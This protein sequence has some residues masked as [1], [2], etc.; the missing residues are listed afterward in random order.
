MNAIDTNILVYAL[1]DDEPAKS[2]AAQ[3]L[4][5]SLQP[6]DT[7]LLWQVA[8]EFGAVV[9]RLARQRRIST[10]EQDAWHMARSRFRLV[11]PEAS[12]LELASGLRSRFGVSYWD[13]M[14]IA[15]CLNAGVTTL[16]SEDRQSAPKIEGIT[17]VDPF[18]T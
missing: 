1:S 13:S 12:C 6:T 17:I 9:A 18:R 8:V 14:I 15:A 5:R 10:T 4:L 3:Q 2:L 16:Y 7:V 11:L